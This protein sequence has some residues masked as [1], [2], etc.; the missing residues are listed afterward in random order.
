MTV[1]E[2]MSLLQKDSY[3]VVVTTNDEEGGPLTDRH[4]AQLES[5]YR[6]CL[7]QAKENGLKSITFCCISTGV[8]MFPSDKAAQIAVETVKKFKYNNSYQID[9][10]FNVFKNIDFDIYKNLLLN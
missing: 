8:F 2:F 10:I 6:S 5:C 4:E 3:S 1:R 7:E 9:V